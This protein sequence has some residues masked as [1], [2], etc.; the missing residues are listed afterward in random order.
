[1]HA[2]DADR[3]GLADGQRVRVRSRTGSVEVELVRTADVMPGVV[4]LPHGF[5]HARAGVRL[6]VAR[7]HAGVSAND[8]TD[9]A[10]FDK[11]SGNAA[12]NGVPVSVEAIGG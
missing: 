11:V 1:M 4:S 6:S 5:G 2:E 12:L 3:L 9:E 7:E 10:F 8:L